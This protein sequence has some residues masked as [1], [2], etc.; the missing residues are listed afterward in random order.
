LLRNETEFGLRV[1]ELAPAFGKNEYD[2]AMSR[3]EAKNRETATKA[4]QACAD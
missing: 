2:A 1:M 3:F 4:A